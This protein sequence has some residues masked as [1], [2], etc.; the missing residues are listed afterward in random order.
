MINLGIKNK[1]NS[2]FSSVSIFV[3][4]L[5][6]TSMSHRSETLTAV[7]VSSWLFEFFSL[8]EK[9][10][11]ITR[12]KR[13]IGASAL[14]FPQILISSSVPKKFCGLPQNFFST[15]E[16]KTSFNADVIRNITQPPLENFI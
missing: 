16:I 15:R 4:R 8:G 2:F 7:R 14:Q 5:C 10:I 11:L 12:I 6:L 1:K 9:K 13:E 3:N